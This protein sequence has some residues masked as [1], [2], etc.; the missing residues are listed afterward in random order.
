MASPRS[1]RPDT[2][3][4]YAWTGLLRY[5]VEEDHRTTNALRLIVTVAVCMAF[6]LAA[7]G[8]VALGV[9][10]V[11]RTWGWWPLV[12]LGSGVAGSG[13][14]IGVTRWARTRSSGQPPTAP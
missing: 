14:L 7:L 13:G 4:R 5:V 8:I 9:V 3:S 1:P 2:S 11:Q 6:V 10:A 12:G